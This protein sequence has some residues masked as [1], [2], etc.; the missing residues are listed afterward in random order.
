MLMG[1]IRIFA[2]VKI[3][4]LLQRYAEQEKTIEILRCLDDLNPQR[5]H[6]KGLFCSSKALLAATLYFKKARNYCFVFA[7]KDEAHYFH[8]DLES[9]SD[10]MSGA[11]AMNVTF[12][13]GAG[14][15]LFGK[16]CLFDFPEA[17][18]KIVI[19]NRKLMFLNLD[20]TMDRISNVYHELPI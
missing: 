1:I 18:K 4:E 19:N 3:A 20:G 15:R 7:N 9:L 5:L 2:T 14:E 12:V 13:S 11:E 6:L 16:T 10:G 8:T 17:L